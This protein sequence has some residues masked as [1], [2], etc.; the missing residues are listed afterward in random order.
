MGYALTT[1]TRNGLELAVLPW[2]DSDTLLTDAENFLAESD[3]RFEISP[4]AERK[5]FYHGFGCTCARCTKAHD[6]SVQVA[7]VGAGAISYR[8]TTPAGKNY[9]P[10]VNIRSRVITC[11]CPNGQ[12]LYRA[13]CYHAQAAWLNYL[14]RDRRTA[15]S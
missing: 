7:G 8:I 2:E 11:N 14:T 5:D 12:H 6:C 10:V 4:D 1:A 9:L 3:A 13:T 15:L